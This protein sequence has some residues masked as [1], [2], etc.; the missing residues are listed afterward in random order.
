MQEILRVGVNRKRKNAVRL[1]S[2]ILIFVFA[3]DGGIVHHVANAASEQVVSF[4][5]ESGYYSSPFDLSL[6]SKDGNKVYYTMDG[7]N[8][9][10]GSA[11]TIE[12]TNPIRIESNKGKEPIL[13]TS[14]NTR[15]FSENQFAFTPDKNILDRATIIRAMSVDAEGT[16]SPISTRTYFVGNDIMSQY[17]N[18]AVISLVTDPDNLLNDTSGIYVNG[19][20]YAT[21]RDINDANYMQQGEE[22][23]RPAYMEFFDGS[24]VASVSQGVGIRIH[25][26]YSRRNL[27]KS[28]NIYFRE[29]YDYGTK[30]L[31]GFELIKD[32]YSVYDN[33]T[34][35][36]HK[37]TDKY[38]N[39]M[40]RNGGN[41]SDFT[42]FQDAFIQ[43]M[44][45]DKAFTTQGSRPCILYLN[46]EFWGLYN[47]T[48]KYSDKYLEEKFDVDNNNVIV[49][50]DMEIDEGESLDPVGAALQELLDLGNL[51]MNDPANYQKFKDIVDLQSFIEYYAT[52]IYINNN[53]WFSGTN[54]ETPHNNIEFW[55]VADPSAEALRGGANNPYADGKWRYMLYDTEWSMGLY[56][57]AQAGAAYDSIKYHAI[58]EPDPSDPNDARRTEANGDP[59][60]TAVF[61]NEGFRKDF[62]NALL[63]VRNWNFEYSRCAKVLDEYTSVYTP[64]MDSNKK[65]WNV[66]N[67]SGR[68]SEIKNFLS[69]RPNYILSIL[70]DNIVELNSSDR[71][72]VTVKNNIA[73]QDAIKV[74]TIK[75]D[76]G[77]GFHGI[78]YKKYPIELTALDQEGY[79]FDHWDVSGAIASDLYSK[80]TYFTLNDPNASIE[81][82]YKVGSGEATVT[83]TPT[84]APEAYEAKFEVNNAS[85]TTYLRQDYE[86]PTNA[87]TNQTSAY[88]RNADTGELDSSGSGQVNFTVIPDSGYI[89]DNVEVTPMNYK[90]IKLPD[91]TLKENTYR[92][93]K[94]TGNIVI[95]VTTKYVG[96][97][98][99]PTPTVTPTPPITP[100]PN[101]N[102]DPPSSSNP[103]VIY[104][105]PSTP[106]DDT[107]TV[108]VK[109]DT[110]VEVKVTID[111]KI[112]V[113]KEI[114]SDELAKIVDSYKNFDILID[115]SSIDGITE[116][117][118]TKTTID[119]IMKAMQEQSSL[120]QFVI[121]LPH[122]EISL[123]ETE[124]NSLVEKASGSKVII[125]IENKKED[126]LN[127]VQQT[128][129]FAKGTVSKN[130]V[131]IT[132]NKVEDAEGYVIYGAPCGNKYKK[133]GT[134]TSLSFTHSNLP[135]D[136]RYKYYVVAYKK[137]DGKV[138]SLGKT[139]KI[140]ITTVS[141]KYTNT[142]SISLEE[143]AL[144]S[145]TGDVSV[146]S[147]K[148]NKVSTSKKLLLHVAKLRYYSTD[149]SIAEVDEKGNITSK[150]LGTC[151]IYLLTNDGI[152]T[153]LSIT[154]K[155]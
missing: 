20:K 13:T 123:D 96:V 146:I 149:S 151:D 133:L 134:S 143:E 83:P 110:S 76:T 45:S 2:M 7:C 58:G 37:V 101:N 129:F 1:L 125:E 17:N 122:E 84:I 70:E 42:K 81:A 33:D 78:Y 66:G 43:K 60:F 31:S 48:E 80:I 64:L 144:I 15:K 120:K 105:P 130:S 4:S 94:V 118:M 74:N 140:H 79:V 152:L 69:Q 136:T 109:L 112:A 14:S 104:I 132:Y 148:V 116:V 34:G 32:T 5:L 95:T 47:L 6:T 121:K 59:V 88:A 102:P 40:L 154:V 127:A 92:I 77:S 72:N 103:P 19:D 71:V 106:V 155:Y 52:E 119:N 28:L 153:K 147:A 50:K 30:N 124:L 18:C 86:D 137:V 63:D 26:G 12:Y 150:K 138:V 23:E 67:V 55:K 56:G 117:E 139:P 90:N 142:K 73:S 141:S 51:D 126:S 16:C 131:K 99:T 38:K 41:D 82:I 65:R 57:S 68:V 107:E 21:T 9:V 113:V 8:P 53:D 114:T 100:D 108:T 46:G 44:V 135:K 145:K 97:T 93:T 25:G 27:Q 61:K 54:N 115:L 29:D 89:V 75:P 39:I 87:L 85:I 128:M 11:S 10:V 35:A 98:N 91:E 22:W 24:N 62:T 49:Y 111:S 3:F 36:I